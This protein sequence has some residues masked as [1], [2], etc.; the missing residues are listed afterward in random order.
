MFENHK[1]DAKAGVMDLKDNNY[2]NK[3]LRLT[4]LPRLYKLLKILRIFK[5]LRLFKYSKILK[6]II[7]G[8][9]INSGIESMLKILFSTFILVHLM[10]CFWFLVAKLEN[11]DDATWVS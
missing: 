9:Q 2:I 5:T 11:F 3:L 1:I 7:S 10:S 8:I 6:A 4:R